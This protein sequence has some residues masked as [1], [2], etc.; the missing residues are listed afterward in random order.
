MQHAMRIAPYC[1]QWPL[2][3]YHIY[4]QYFMQDTN[5]QI[6]VTEQQARV[7]IFTTNFV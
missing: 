4:P 7:V 2:W 5:F 6:N 1:H 3:L